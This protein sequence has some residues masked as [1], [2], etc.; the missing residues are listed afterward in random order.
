MLSGPDWVV[1]QAVERRKRELE[2]ED[3]EYEEKLA[4]ARKTE[5]RLR[6]LARTRVTKKPVRPNLACITY[7]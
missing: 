5:A 4:K 7:S 2:T 6:K 1:A 3:Q